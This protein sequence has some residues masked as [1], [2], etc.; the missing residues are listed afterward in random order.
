[1][2]NKK[3]QVAIGMICILLGFLVTLQVR[4]VRLNHLTT[5]IARN[6]DLLSELNRE[7]S[8]NEDLLAQIAIL[9]NDISMYQDKASESNGYAKVLKEQLERAQMVSGQVGVQGPGV[10]LT[11]DDSKLKD[12]PTLSS[13]QL[14]VHESD[15]LRF[16]NELYASGAEAIAIN[17]ERLIS[18]SAIRCVGPVIIIN[19]TRK[20]PPYNISAIGDTETMYTA[21]TMTDGLVDL[22]KNVYYLDVQIKK[23][24]NIV[25]PSYSGTI[26]FKNAVLVKREGLQ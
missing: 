23:E 18:N 7:R 24:K 12:N 5:D 16:I 15:I 22:Y 3:G 13:D 14:I 4:S 26:N 1:M 9:S 2:R 8:K 19:N 25:L 17:G 21:L 11:L 10:M 6:E 20:A